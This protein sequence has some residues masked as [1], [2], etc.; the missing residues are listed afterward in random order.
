VYRV[1]YYGKDSTFREHRIIYSAAVYSIPRS[2]LLSL[3]LSLSEIH[4][5]P[6]SCMCTSV[7][8]VSENLA[9]EALSPPPSPLAGGLT[10]FPRCRSPCPVAARV[11]VTS[12][13]HYRREERLDSREFRGKN[14]LIRMHKPSASSPRDDG[15]PTMW[16]RSRKRRVE[17]ERTRELVNHETLHNPRRFT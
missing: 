15:V 10:L 8:S 1:R 11:P 9:R 6:A 16:N 7:C 4:S 5:L 12:P 3:S 14:F 17:K 2:I 13:P